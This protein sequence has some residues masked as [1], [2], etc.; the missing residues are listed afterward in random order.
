MLF[1]RTPLAIS[2]FA[3]LAL[4]GCCCHR[5]VRSCAPPTAVTVPLPA[6]PVVPTLP[7]GQVV[8]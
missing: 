5:P 1:R 7:P 6:G 2:L 8:P 4:A 3:L